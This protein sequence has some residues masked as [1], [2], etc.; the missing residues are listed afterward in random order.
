ME[1]FQ[2]GKFLE[3]NAAKKHNSVVIVQQSE[4]VRKLSN[5]AIFCGNFPT[6]ELLL[7]IF[8]QS[9]KIFVKFF[10]QICVYFDGISPTKQ[11]EI[12][13]EFCNKTA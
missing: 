11:C 4:L 3:E 12:W 13:K 2:E 6:K 10:K 5:K 1:I 8:Q 9:C 7:E